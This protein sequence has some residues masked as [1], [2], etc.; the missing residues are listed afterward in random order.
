MQLL[1]NEVAN[2]FILVVN[3]ELKQL[4]TPFPQNR[5]SLFVH[6]FVVAQSKEQSNMM[7]RVHPKIATSE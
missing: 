3:L 4:M 7:H 2:F 5:L 6:K 1:V